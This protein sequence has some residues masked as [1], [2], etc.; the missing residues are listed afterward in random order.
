MIRTE[1][2]DHEKMRDPAEQS[3]QSDVI[4]ASV[5]CGALVVPHKRIQ[6]EEIC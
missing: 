5:N 3:P 6:L 4:A 1:L 2:Q